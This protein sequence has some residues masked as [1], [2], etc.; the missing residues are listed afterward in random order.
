MTDDRPA[1]RLEPSYRWC[2][3]EGAIVPVWAYPDRRHY[4]HDL[5]GRLCPADHRQVAIKVSKREYP[6]LRKASA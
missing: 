5:G 2:M 3:A 4:R 6:E 1:W